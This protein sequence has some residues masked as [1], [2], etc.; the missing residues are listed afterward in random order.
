MTEVGGIALPGVTKGFHDLADALHGAQLWLKGHGAL[1]KH[2]QNEITDAV[3]ETEGWITA[4]HDDWVQL[5][6]D[7]LWA[8][9]NLNKA[10]HSLSELADD[11]IAFSKAAH[12]VGAWYDSWTAPLKWAIEHASPVTNIVHS[13]HD[14]PV[15]ASALSAAMARIKAIETSRRQHG[16]G[17]LSPGAVLP[18]RN[19]GDPFGVSQRSHTRRVVHEHNVHLVGGHT[20]ARHEVRRVMEEILTAGTADPR[21]DTGRHATIQT[22]PRQ[23][24]YLTTPAPP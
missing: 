24:V 15:A 3:K 2:I 17:D 1:E 7:A 5:R 16:F 23:P 10:G 4:R 13:A 8:M 18:L 14:V 20:V 21:H 22:S 6:G 11:A 9:D 12:A 19:P